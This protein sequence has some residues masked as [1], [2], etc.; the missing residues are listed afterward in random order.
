[1]TVKNKVATITS[2]VYGLARGQLRTAGRALIILLFIMQGLLSF[3][4]AT[5]APSKPAPSKQESQPP[6]L[7]PW[8]RPREFSSFQSLLLHSPFSLATAEES[9][10]LSERY[11][12][13]GIITI[14][15]EEE[16]F[17]LDKN[18]QSRELL[19]KKPNKKMMSLVNIVKEPDPNKLKATITINGESGVIT[20]PELNTNNPIHGPQR[21]SGPNPPSGSNQQKNIFHPPN[22]P[23]YPGQTPPNTLQSQGTPSSTNNP[24]NHRVI[25]RSPI[26]NQSIPTP[27]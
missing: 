20:N 14:D 2:E 3:A 15:G 9:S 5:E 17:V 26:P 18:D 23:Y 24:N 27:Q 16:I 22:T 12:I 21:F 6:P 7:P 19:T 8:M 13:T 25:Y 1:M 4:R 10:P 11:A